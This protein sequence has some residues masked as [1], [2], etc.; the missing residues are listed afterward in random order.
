M[1]E[2]CLDIVRRNAVTNLDYKI[3][4][5]EALPLDDNSVDMALMHQTLH[6]A[7]HPGKAISEAARILRPGGKLVVFDLLKHNFDT[8]RQMY[9]DLWLGFSRAELN[10]FLEKAGFKTISVTIVDREIE[11]PQFEILLAMGVKM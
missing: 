3:G 7:S 6:H 9:G 10:D 4:D 5:M 11:P 2:Y 8:A 1:A